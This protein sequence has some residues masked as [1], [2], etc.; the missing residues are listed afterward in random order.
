MFKFAGAIIIVVFFSLFGIQKTNNLHKRINSLKEFRNM[1]EDLK[2]EIY[3]KNTMLPD[4][5]KSIGN[6]YNNNCFINWA[7][8]ME[9]A[10]AEKSFCYALDSMICEFMLNKND[11]GV[12]KC[13]VASIG[14]LEIGSQIKRLDGGIAALDRH[15]NEVSA[16]CT[17]KVRLYVGSSVLMGIFTVIILI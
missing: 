16:A 2:F 13:I 7:A 1:F 11:I 15:I 17:E 14:R 9:G 3:L 10:C 6:K 4:A 12:I 5:V 8:N